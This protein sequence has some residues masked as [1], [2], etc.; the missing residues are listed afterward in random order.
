MC[1]VSTKERNAVV[2]I[3]TSC[4]AYRPHTRAVLLGWSRKYPKP[5]KPTRGNPSQSSTLVQPRIAADNTKSS[6]TVSCPNHAVSYCAHAIR[7]TLKN[8]GLLDDKM[9]AVAYS[10]GSHCRLGMTLGI[11]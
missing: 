1:I 11:D 10:S 3:S 8:T 4:V 7:Q 6:S 5:D 2:H 9:I